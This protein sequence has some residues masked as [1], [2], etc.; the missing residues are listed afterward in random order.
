MKTKQIIT[1][2]LFVIPNLFFGQDITYKQGMEYKFN[3]E[4]IFS[5]KAVIWYGMDF[6]KSKLTNP[7]PKKL[8]QGSLMKEKYVPAWMEIVNER[9]YS[10]LVKEKLKKDTVIKDLISIQQLFKTID[11]KKFISSAEYN[12]TIDSVKSVVKNYKLPQTNGVGCVL[13][14]ENLNAPD[15]FVTGYFTFFDIETKDVL[16]V[17]KAKR[18]PNGN[19]GFT[20]YWKEGIEGLIDYSF[21]CYKKALKFFEQV[22]DE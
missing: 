11:E 15:V 12:F 2:S 1:I 14:L 7:D 4:K 9:Y 16:Y 8:D 3:I 6:S 20:Q 17:I 18:K 13:I 19:Y 22:N 10:E 5:A 21:M